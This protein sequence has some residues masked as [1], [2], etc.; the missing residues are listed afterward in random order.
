[1]AITTAFPTQAKQDF[2]DGVHL[3]ADI[4]KIALYVGTA[5]LDAA[6]TGYITTGEVAAGGGYGA[7]GIQLSGRTV[8]KAGT[9]GF[10]S[11]NDAVWAGATF[12]ARG[13][14][15]YNESKVGKPA[16]GIWDFGAD[17][18][19]GGGNFTVDFPASGAT[20]LIRIG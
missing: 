19:G 5:I 6:T 7:G 9:V 13:C 14:M 10:L 18:T 20:A 4:Y 16:I 8:G 3:P 2:L 11:F 12:T 17:Q 1:M 15:V